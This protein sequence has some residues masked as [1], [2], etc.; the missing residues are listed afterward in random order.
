MQKK[1]PSATLIYHFFYPDD[2][3]SAIHFSQFAEELAKRNWDVTAL[4]SN[5]YCRY[6][7]RA[8]YPRNELWNKVRI[9]RI[10]RPGWNQADS[11]GRMFNSFWLIAGWSLKLLRMPAADVIIV[12]T[13]PQFSALLFPILKLLR[14]GKI[15]V[16]WCYDVYPDAIFSD[17]E[18]KIIK[19]ILYFLKFI[20]KY[21]Y[22]FVDIMVDI[23]LCMRRRLTAYKHNAK[24]ITLVPWAIIESPSMRQADKKIRAEL[25]TDTVKLALLYSGNMGKA[26]DYLLFLQLARILYVRN[27]EI[28]F[29]FACRGN[30][31]KELLSALRP[32]DRNIHLAPFV[33]VSGLK[34]RL[35]AADIHLLSLRSEWEGI[36][37]PSKFFGSL[38]VG[39]PVIFSGSDNSSIAEWIKSFDLGWILTQR[40]LEKIADELANIA[41][42]NLNK[43]E[44]LKANAYNAYYNNFSKKITMDNWDC[45]LKNELKR[46]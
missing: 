28:V 5:R 31:T 30:R 14:K 37:V 42:S 19:P 39:R 15:L 23:G 33:G 35:I 43:L 25:F 34:E 17:N 40:N 38:A 8:I 2:V 10:A 46:N 20:I 29:C 32:S 9:I 36:V 3:V 12:G 13:D 11:L 26:H 41:D 21:A 7:K 16:H 6:P 4:T 1:C 27:P 22:C 44:K 24:C 18:R 45:V